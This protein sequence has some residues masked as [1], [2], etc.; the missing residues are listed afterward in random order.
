[1]NQTFIII[2]VVKDVVCCKLINMNCA[3]VGNFFRIRRKIFDNFFNYSKV[4]NLKKLCPPF[5]AFFSDFCSENDKNFKKFLA[6]PFRLLGITLKCFSLK[7]SCRPL[8][9][10]VEL[11]S[12]SLLEIM[13]LLY[14]LAL[15]LVFVVGR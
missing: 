1:M 14:V 13:K 10:T 12:V 15:V 9:S 8:P 5:S 6:E 11:F 7:G 2:V 4:E 3:Y